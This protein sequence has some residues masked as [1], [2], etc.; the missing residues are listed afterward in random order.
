MAVRAVVLF[1]KIPVLAIGVQ[2]RVVGDLSGRV[3]PHAV[4]EYA[5]RLVGVVADVNVQRAAEAFLRRDVL[6]ARH[7][8]ELLAR[9]RMH[10]GTVVDRQQLCDARFERARGGRL[11]RGHLRRV[12]RLTAVV[13]RLL[14]LDVRRRVGD[15]QRNVVRRLIRPTV[16]EEDVAVRAD[17]ARKRAALHLGG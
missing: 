3:V 7:R 17:R 1:A 13:A 2:L 11:R 15:H 5:G 10:L 6:R 16:A 4:A 9:V 14:R 12:H 8:R